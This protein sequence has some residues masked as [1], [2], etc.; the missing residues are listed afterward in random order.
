MLFA[1][2]SVDISVNSLKAMANKTTITSA[3][4]KA[5]VTNYP[6]S[7]YFLHS[8]R[9]IRMIELQAE[10]VA[11]LERQTMGIQT[12]VSFSCSF[13]S[14]FVTRDKIPAYQ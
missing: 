1:F 11:L 12:W 4:T 13:L 2:F 3:Q 5:V 7:H 9:I 8:P 14:V 6:G 10:L